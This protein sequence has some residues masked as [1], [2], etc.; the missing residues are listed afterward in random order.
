MWTEISTNKNKILMGVIYQ[1]PGS[2]DNIWEYISQ[3]IEEVLIDYGH[4]III[5]G[6]LNDNLL[7]DGNSTL[8]D[9]INNYG[10]TQVIT[11]PTR[12]T[13]TSQ[14]LLDPI[15]TNNE[16]FIESSGVL[17]PICSDH[18]P[19]YAT[20]RFYTPNRTYKKHIWKYDNGDYDA[21]NTHFMNTNWDYMLHNNNLENAVKMVTEKIHTVAS[22]SIP[23]F[24]ITIRPKDPPWITNT[25]RKQIR[26]RNRKHK[27]AKMTNRQEHWSSFRQQRNKVTAEIRKAKKEFPKKIARNLESNI[28]PKKWWSLVNTLLRGNSPKCDI[29]TM[30]DGHSVISEDQEKA[31]LFNDYFINQTHLD[32][33][34]PTPLLTKKTNNSLLE[35]VLTE[36]DIIEAIQ[37]L[38]PG[39]SAGMDEI[40]N[41]VL[42][43]CA[44]SLSYPLCE[45]FNK[46]LRE[47]IYPDLWKL[48]NV[49]PIYKKGD[50]KDKKNYRPVSLLSC[51]G[52][53]MERCVFKHLFKY[54]TTNNIITVL[55]SG[56]KPGDS[57]INQMIDIY[58]TIACAIDGKEVRSVFCDISKAF[59]RVWHR[60]LLSKLRSIG[61]RGKILIWMSSYLQHRKQRVVIHGQTSQFKELSAGVPQGSVLGPLLFIIFINDIVD[62]I[63]CDIRLFADDTSLSIAVEDPKCAAKL[64]NEDLE[65]IHNWARKW[66]V[67]FNPAKT[68]TMT[69]S[70]KRVKVIHPP[71]EFG[72]TTLEQVTSHKHLGFVLSEDC[73]WKRH[74][75]SICSKAGQGCQRS[76]K[77]QGK[78]IFS[79]SVKSQGISP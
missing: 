42:K 67:S 17:D 78:N 60:G 51:L 2:D 43:Q 75:D 22:E 1:P 69:F 29:P 65:K 52:K 16:H 8:Q 63:T 27:K 9:I 40:H 77:S 61:I 57:T 4:D 45:L 33:N 37:A 30:L 36:Q 24:D 66:L 72:S 21:M 25:I 47:G 74:V 3:C 71:L 14:T 53:L 28:T 64:L 48:A 6:D 15:I 38:K 12:I 13:P 70:N 49:V 7:T 62:D 23:N 26:K 10:L 56:F 20:V 31:E 59:D 11:E 34:C 19:T 44:Q 41:K 73:K 68:K 76:G 46:S 50:R 35:I 39:K 55:Q 18:C 58:H 54:L 5:V 79:R 32:E